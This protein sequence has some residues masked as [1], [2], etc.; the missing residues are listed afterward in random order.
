MYEKAQELIEEYNHG[1]D[2][3]KKGKETL[4]SLLTEKGILSLNALQ[5]I[6][7]GITEAGKINLEGTSPE[8]LPHKK[9]SMPLS[10]DSVTKVLKIILSDDYKTP[11]NSTEIEWQLASISVLY[12]EILPSLNDVDI[13]LL[14]KI[15][16][17]TMKLLS[18]AVEIE[19]DLPVTERK[20]KHRTKVKAGKIK[21]KMKTYKL[22]FE[23][24]QRMHFSDGATKGEKAKKI[25]NELNESMK[26]SKDVPDHRTIVRHIEEI[27]AK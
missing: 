1:L 9:K 18:S 8:T 26:K 25:W 22:I 6:A 5:R 27:E 16:L 20:M 7:K 13:R 17:A 21:Q 19:K 15:D 3:D 12:R 2:D 10:D 23:V 11:R 14:Q 4:I 24:Y